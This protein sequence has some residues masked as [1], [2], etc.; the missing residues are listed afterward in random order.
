MCQVL[1]YMSVCSHSFVPYTII[2]PF[3]GRRNSTLE[4][5]SNF[6]KVTQPSN[7]KLGFKPGSL[8]ERLSTEKCFFDSWFSPCKQSGKRQLH[9]K[10]LVITT[11]IIIITINTANKALCHCVEGT[12]QNAQRTKRHPAPPHVWTWPLNPSDCFKR[13]HYHTAVSAHLTRLPRMYL[14]LTAT[15]CFCSATYLLLSILYCSY[16][17]TFSYSQAFAHCWVLP[18]C[19]YTFFKILLRSYCVPWLCCLT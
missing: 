1:S 14:L 13:L 4:K 2:T 17:Y 15:F 10:N 6:S 9:F 5:L 11:I 7:G 19:C 3:Y 16:L 18:G 8:T 12:A